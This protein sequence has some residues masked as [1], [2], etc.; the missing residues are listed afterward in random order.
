MSKNNHQN[1]F[2]HDNS[3]AKRN[4]MFIAMDYIYHSFF[5]HKHYLHKVGLEEYVTFIV[6]K[7]DA[8]K[9]LLDNLK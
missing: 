3:T 8:H 9:M 2:V 6:E 5:F 4:N 7:T 1:S